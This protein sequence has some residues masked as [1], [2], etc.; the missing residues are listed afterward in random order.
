MKVILIIDSL[1]NA[2][3]EKSLLQIL[4]FFSKEIDFKIVY[5][6]PKH[7]L[8]E[9]YLAAGMSLEFLDLEGKYDFWNGYSRLWKLVEN[10]QSDLLVSSLLRANLLTRLISFRTGVPLIG[11]FVS[12]SYNANRIGAKSWIQ[13]I[14]FKFFWALD[15]MTAGIPKRY[16]SNSRYIAESHVRTLGVPLPKSIVVYRGRAVP[17]QVWKARQGDIFRFVSYGRLLKVKGFGELIE[18]FG[19]VTGKYPN[20]SLVINGEGNYRLELENLIEKLGLQNKIS[21]SGVIPNVTEKLYDADCFIFPSWYEGFSGALVEAMLAGIPIIASDI[22]MNLEAIKE[23]ESAL[24]FK[25]KNVN[26]LAEK[27]I[28]AIEHQEE[29]ESYGRKAREVAK[30]RFDIKIIAK[31]Y[32]EVLWK[33]YNQYVKKET[34]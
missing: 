13:H 21:L 31:Q 4:P 2:G 9:E 27:M 22:P 6:Y 18:A 5:L 29:I 33:V 28:Y 34:Y 14:K 23:K 20:S 16:I 15:R 19:K 1:A 12:D 24:I 30:E 3:T 10:E 11:T 26:D 17:T 7:D 32:E 8:R 25:V